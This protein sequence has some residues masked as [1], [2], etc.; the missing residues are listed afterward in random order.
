M[1]RQAN[2]QI[3]SEKSISDNK[4]RMKSNSKITRNTKE[5]SDSSPTTLPA[6]DENDET[7]NGPAEPKS[8]KKVRA[9]KITSK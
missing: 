5:N 4:S 2:G 9:A 8:I 7:K 1:K 3:R 6:K